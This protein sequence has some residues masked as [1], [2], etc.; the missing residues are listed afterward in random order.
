M[1][2]TLN[3][4]LQV[5]ITFLLVTIGWVFFRSETIKD[6]IGYLI[7]MISDIS[8]FTHLSPKIGFYTLILILVDWTQRYNE[9]SLFFNFPKFLFKIF[10]LICIVLILISFKNDSQQFIYFDF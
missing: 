1:L 9:R 7:S 8:T 2:P 3:E 10:V 4:F 5:V 6:S